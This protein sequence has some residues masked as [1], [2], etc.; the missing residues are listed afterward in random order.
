MNA[1]HDIEYFDLFDATENEEK[2]SNKVVIRL[3]P[4]EKLNKDEIKIMREK[5]EEYVKGYLKNERK[6]N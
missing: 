4:H 1:I 3:C 5:A 6:I 2:T